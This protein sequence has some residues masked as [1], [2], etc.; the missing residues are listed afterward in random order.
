MYV[1]IV[2][3]TLFQSGLRSRSWNEHDQKSNLKR[4]DPEQETTRFKKMGTRSFL[5]IPGYERSTGT[6]FLE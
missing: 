1:N 2:Y 3:F 6:G 4:N 5:V